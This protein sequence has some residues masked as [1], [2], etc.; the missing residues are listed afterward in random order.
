M[1][2]EIIIVHPD[3]N[4][5][6]STFL[7]KRVKFSCKKLWHCHCP[8]DAQLGCHFFPDKHLRGHGAMLIYF[9]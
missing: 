6:M 9:K 2:L 4:N 3:S 7:S 8:A 1:V 5:Q